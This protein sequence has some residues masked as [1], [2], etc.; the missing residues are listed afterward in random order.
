MKVLVVG[1]GAREHALALACARSA[2]VV[3]APG[4]GAMS[5]SVVDGHTI[6]I[7]PA[8]PEEV[9][10]D[11]VVIG[12][13]AP[14]VAGLADRLRAKGRAVVGPGHDGARL[15]GSKAFMKELCSAAN[16]PTARFAI[17]DRLDAAIDHLRSSRGPYVI[18]TDGLA[19][20]K[21]VFVTDDLSAAERDVQDKLCGAAF[22]DA[23]RRVVI[24]E[25]LAGAE[26]SLLAL[27]DGRQAVPFPV[28]RDFKRVGDGDEGPNTGGMGAFSPVPGVSDT[29]VSDA[30]DRIVEPALAELAR[31]GVEYR[32]VLYAGLMLTDDGVKLIEF[33]V[34]FGDPEAEVVVPRLDCDVVGLFA[35]AASGHPSDEIRA[36]DDAAVCVVIAAP[37][38]PVSPQTGDV[39]DGIK[40]AEGVA[41]VMV[42]H[43]GTERG[44]DGVIRSAGG[45]VLAVTAC[46][47]NLKD[48]RQ[49]AYEAVERIRFP[50]ATYRR[51]IADNLTPAGV[52]SAR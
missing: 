11:L 20:G 30:M 23:G 5:A 33:N 41:G 42:F 9:E 19:G 48:A 51:D 8:P 29:V 10:A 1:S 26:V 12:P 25:A 31:R 13:E 52:R 37:G 21:G 3:V 47:L 4:R 6:S 28:A 44:R 17:F 18:K 46:A 22:G 35:A 50:S 15:E 45:R 14:L 2:D 43:A 39:I 38:Y 24:E 16:I 34:R 40:D 32:G 49:R 7:S 36:I 27:C